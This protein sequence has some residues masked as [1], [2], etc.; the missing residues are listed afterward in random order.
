[1]PIST[2][3]VLIIYNL[4]EPDS[5]RVANYYISARGLNSANKLGFHWGTQSN[6]NSGVGFNTDGTDHLMAT[7]ADVVT[8][9]N[10]INANAIEAVVLSILCPAGIVNASSHVVSLENVMGSAQHWK[11][12]GSIVSS[13]NAYNISD[14]ITSKTNPSP[15]GG[16]YSSSNPGGT[17]SYD[18]RIPT[19]FH[20]QGNNNWIPHGRIGIP[21]YAGNLPTETYDN[22]I[23]YINTALA[24]E[25]SIASAASLPIHYH[26]YD[27]YGYPQTGTATTERAR[28]MAVSKGLAYQICRISGEIN[29][30]GSPY[31]NMADQWCVP[32]DTYSYDDLIHGR[33]KPPLWGLLGDDYVWNFEQDG[34]PNVYTVIPGAWGA[35]LQSYGGRDLAVEILLNGGAAVT[36]C[37]YE[38]QVQAQLTQEVFLNALLLGVSMMEA[39]SY[40]NMLGGW[41][42]TTLGDPLYRPFGKQNTMLIG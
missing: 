11:Q 9:A 38:P 10:Y 40:S 28:L 33:I 4:D 13:Q 37:V 12:V 34:T 31:Q 23:G 14:S 25:Q 30:N 22:S 27:R 36:G 20:W 24:S 16:I 42:M 18:V 21:Q 41:M 35:G 5:L 15:P 6:I 32:A 39:A 19:T 17:F 29:N 2:N 8:V 26:Y 3:K 7:Y 1:M